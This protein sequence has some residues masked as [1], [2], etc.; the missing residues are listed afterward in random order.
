MKADSSFIIEANQSVIVLFIFSFSLILQLYL[1][2]QTKLD[3]HDTHLPSLSLTIECQHPSEPTIQSPLFSNF[4]TNDHNSSW[5]SLPV[6][7]IESD[8][9]KSPFSVIEQFPRNTSSLPVKTSRDLV[10][11]KPL[12]LPPSVMTGTSLQDLHA[13]NS[14]QGN[15]IN[16][17]FKQTIDVHV[18]NVTSFLISFLLD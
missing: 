9:P 6:S 11:Q 13:E 3:Y 1:R 4:T 14:L 8:E 16:S 2:Y 5:N 7:P 18:E 10:N 12:M 17:T 15:Q